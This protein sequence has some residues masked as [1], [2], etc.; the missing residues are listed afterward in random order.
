MDILPVGARACKKIFLQSARPILLAFVLNSAYVARCDA[1]IR[2]K[3]PTNCD[4]RF[5]ES[6]LGVCSSIIYEEH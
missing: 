3:F 4:A 2:N 5:A 6:I 1:F